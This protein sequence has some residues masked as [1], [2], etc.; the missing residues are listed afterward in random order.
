MSNL[1]QQQ[2]IASIP[3]PPTAPLPS[4]PPDLPP[5]EDG[6]YTDEDSI[7]LDILGYVKIDPAK[8]T[9]NQDWLLVGP[10]T[11][12]HIIAPPRR[13]ASTLLHSGE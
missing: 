6:F 12:A 1:W 8:P 9:H 5:Q 11:T 3:I 4:L 10:D 13:R 2:L 7:G